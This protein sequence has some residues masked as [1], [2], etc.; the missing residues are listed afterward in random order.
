MTEIQ[1]DSKGYCVRKVN[2][3]VSCKNLIIH[4]VK[5]KKLLHIFHRE[6]ARFHLDFRKMNIQ[7]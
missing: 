2:L 1:E 5:D 4:Q 6:E 7:G 3:Q